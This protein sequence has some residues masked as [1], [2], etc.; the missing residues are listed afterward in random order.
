LVK[1][2]IYLD[3][4]KRGKVEKDEAL[5]RQVSIR[6]KKARHKK[7]PLLYIHKN[8]GARYSKATKLFVYL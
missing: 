7:A 6:H 8:K 3:K 4:E 2:G 1:K 5:C